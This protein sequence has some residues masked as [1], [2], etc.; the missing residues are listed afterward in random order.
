MEAP[1]HKPCGTRHWSKE[2]CPAEQFLAKATKAKPA[3][4]DTKTAPLDSVVSRPSRGGDATAPYKKSGAD[5]PLT[6]TRKAIGKPTRLGQ[7]DTELEPPKPAA[8]LRQQ[9]PV[10]PLECQS[11]VTAVP[12][13]PKRG[14]PKTI[15]DM[16]AYKADKAKEY[17][18]KKKAK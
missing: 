1:I 17:R 12:T 11:Q 6:D 15:L 18:A 13:P 8:L 16:K 5:Q 14:R 7:P 10:A 4:S 3:Q 9:P 2:P